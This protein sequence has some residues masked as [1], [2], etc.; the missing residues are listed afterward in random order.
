MGDPPRGRRGIPSSLSAP[1]S[2]YAYRYCNSNRNEA[3]RGWKR[4]TDAVSG[5]ESSSPSLPP[6]FPPSS[7]PPPPSQQKITVRLV[8]VTRRMHTADP[9]SRAGREGGRFTTS[10]HG[11]EEGEGR[12]RTR[13]R[14]NHGASG[15]PS[16]L[17][18]PLPPCRPVRSRGSCRLSCARR[19]C[20]Y[21]RRC[22]AP[23]LSSV[24]PTPCF[25]G[26]AEPFAYRRARARDISRAGA[27]ASRAL[28]ESRVPPS[29]RG[30]RT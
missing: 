29:P 3:R 9:I 19:C 30:A 8:R 10:G 13:R 4:T 20:C 18:P 11:T 6:S 26:R 27:R 28:K 16:L 5:C 22:I 7:P 15:P 1:P 2:R 24:A 21:C 23:W 25:A 12:R 14:R 17:P